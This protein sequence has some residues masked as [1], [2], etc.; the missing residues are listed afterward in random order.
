[1]AILTTY[2]NVSPNKVFSSNEYILG[3]ILGNNTIPDTYKVGVNSYIF[4][5]SKQ[6]KARI[7][8]FKIRLCLVKFKNVL[9]VDTFATKVTIISRVE[10]ETVFGTF[11]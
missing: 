11:K 7:K 9:L 5:A 4:N 3:E 2:F 1:M 10:K 8:L 6:I